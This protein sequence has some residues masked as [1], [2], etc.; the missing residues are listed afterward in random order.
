[1][2]SFKEVSHKLFNQNLAVSFPLINLMY[3]SDI[4]TLWFNI[5]VYLFLVTITH[6]CTHEISNNI[7]QDHNIAVR[8]I[9]VVMDGK[10][11]VAQV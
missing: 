9:L 8:T 5:I 2:V 6:V 1:M 11:V 4:P 7:T 10:L 3:S